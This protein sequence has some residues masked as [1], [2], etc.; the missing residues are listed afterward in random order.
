[1]FQ[2]RKRLKFGAQ[3]DPESDWNRAAVRAGARI[4]AEAL[5]ELPDELGAER[6]WSL[7]ASLHAVAEAID[8]APDP[9]FA[10]FW[11]EVRDHVADADVIWTADDRWLAP[12]EVILIDPEWRPALEPFH[13]LGLAIVNPLIHDQVASVA[14]DIGVGYLTA[15]KLSAAMKSAGLT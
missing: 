5:K 9:A 8:D 2:D 3:G 6:L 10:S 12:G 4:L 1:P 13:D 7:I 14:E 15:E 11:E